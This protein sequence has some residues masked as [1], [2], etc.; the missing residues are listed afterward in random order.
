ME[1]KI[2]YV[3]ILQTLLAVTLVQAYLYSLYFKFI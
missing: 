2:S 3:Q 1:I